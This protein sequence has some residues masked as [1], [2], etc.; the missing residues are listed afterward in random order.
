MVQEPP[1][2]RCARTT[3]VP[4]FLET[5]EWPPLIELAQIDEKTW[6]VLTRGSPVRRTGLVGLRRIAHVGLTKPRGKT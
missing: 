2:G 5:R 4:D 1:A 6:D 3:T